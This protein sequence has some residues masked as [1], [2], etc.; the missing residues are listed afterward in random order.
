MFPKICS[1]GERIP[2]KLVD[3]I[4]QLESQ[5][6]LAQTDLSEFSEAEVSD[7]LERLTK[8]QANEIFD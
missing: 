6:D 2:Q 4:H 8:L 7:L 3:Q 5:F 1:D